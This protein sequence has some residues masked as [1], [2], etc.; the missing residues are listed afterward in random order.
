MKKENGELERA[1]A[2]EEMK[3]VVDKSLDTQVTI[4]CNDLGYYY[5]V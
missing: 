1:I 4:G 2:S 5:I 3:I